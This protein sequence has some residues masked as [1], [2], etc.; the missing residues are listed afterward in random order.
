MLIRRLLT[1]GAVSMGLLL[2]AAG[3]V[4]DDHTYSE[5]PVVNVAMI[6]TVDGKFEEYMN[7]L[8]T[9]WKQQQ[10]AAKRAGYIVSYEVLAVEPRSPQD[11]DLVLVTR[12]RNWAALDGA[13]AKQDEIARQVE[14]S[15]AAAAK[16]QYERARIRTVLGSSTMQVLQLK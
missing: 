15:V 12:Y 7:W 13:L 4:A 16:A 11:P 8:A 3:A 5:G 1:A 6:R 2:G 10:E 9:T 14:G